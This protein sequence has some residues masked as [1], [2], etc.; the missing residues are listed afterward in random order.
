MSFS[1]ATS[2]LSLQKLS[3]LIECW[4]VSDKLFARLASKMGGEEPKAPGEMDYAGVE[5]EERERGHRSWER[6][7]G[8]QF[9]IK[10][11]EGR[12]L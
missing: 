5:E 8:V 11:N 6:S 7:S 10:E 2:S 4:R 1:G 9:R 12:N 3:V